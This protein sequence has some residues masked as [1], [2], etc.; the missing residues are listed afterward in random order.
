VRPH[1]KYIIGAAVVLAALASG[2]AWAVTG[3]H[4]RSNA[5]K[6]GVVTPVRFAPAGA[7]PAASGLSGDPN[8]LLPELVAA[9]GGHAITEADFGQPLPGWTGTEDPNGSAPP[10]VTKGRWLYFT[11]KAPGEGAALQRPVWEG[12]I[13]AGALKERLHALGDRGLFAV[14]TSVAVPSGEIL[15]NVGGGFGDVA[16]GQVFADGSPNALATDIRAAAS[17]LGF[18]VDSVEVLH[19]LQSAPAVVLTTTDPKGFVSSADQYISQI[20]GGVAKYEGEYLEV[21]DPS[22]DPVFVQASAFRTGVG[23][24]WIRKDLDQRWERPGQVP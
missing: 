13:V 4:D 24:R 9:Y 23:Q 6:R 17:G 2:V 14:N 3:S 10:E 15:R 8:Q 22:G 16:F 19:P 1:M 20:F 11:V 12:N 7:L 21:R 5:L 18:K